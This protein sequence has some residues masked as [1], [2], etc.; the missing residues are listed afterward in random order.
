[1]IQFKMSIVEESKRW[2][3]DSSES[4]QNIKAKPR[5]PTLRK[6]RCYL[7]QC[8]NI[9]SADSDGTSDPFITVWHHETKAKDVDTKTKV[10]EDTL[11]PIFM[12]TLQMD[13]YM[14]ALRMI[15]L[16]GKSH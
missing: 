9:P 6:V 1:M 3:L 15:A 13:Y 5:E 16:L 4:W 11:N 2:T 7:Y 8:K 10:I 12:Q 14:T